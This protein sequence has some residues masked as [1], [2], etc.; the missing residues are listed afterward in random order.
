MQVIPAF[1]FIFGQYYDMTCI[2][3][4]TNLLIHLRAKHQNNHN[5]SNWILWE[6]VVPE[7]KVLTDLRTI[8]AKRYRTCTMVHVPNQQKG[9]S[10]TI[11]QCPWMSFHEIRFLILP[12][13]HQEWCPNCRI[14][15]RAWWKKRSPSQAAISLDALWTLGILMLV[16]LPGLRVSK[17]TCFCRT[18]SLTLR[19]WC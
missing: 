17:D 9:C 13:P 15:R 8:K 11:K 7:Q 16:V 14:V 19:P 6:K 12:P 2:L 18:M 4:A 1:L 3:Y 5:A 10:R